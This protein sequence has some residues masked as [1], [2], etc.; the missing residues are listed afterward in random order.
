MVKRKII[1]IDERKYAGG[2][3]CIPNYQRELIQI[4]SGES[5]LNSEISCDVLEFFI[6]YS[7]TNTTQIEEKNTETYDGKEFLEKNINKIPIKK[8]VIGTDGKILEKK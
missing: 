2:S 7:P 8:I 6:G 3:L 1:N 5:R 4:I